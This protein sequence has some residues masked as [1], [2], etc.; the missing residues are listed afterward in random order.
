MKISLSFILISIVI[1]LGAIELTKQACYATWKDSQLK[2]KW[3]LIG[4]CQVEVKTN[5]WI[6]A[7]NYREVD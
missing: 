2:V 5:V 6:P 4:D 1:F 7:R 3:S